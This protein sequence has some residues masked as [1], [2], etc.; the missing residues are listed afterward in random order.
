M[1]QANTLDFFESTAKL[2][3]QDAKNG[4]NVAKELEVVLEY[5]HIIRGEVGIEK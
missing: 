4:K 1:E 2:L 5:I 3:M